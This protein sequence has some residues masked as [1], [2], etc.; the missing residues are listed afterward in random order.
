M[1]TVTR[2]ATD[3]NT[4][5]SQTLQQIT[6]VQRIARSLKRS[7][8]IRKYSHGTIK[9]SAMAMINQYIRQGG[10]QFST[11]SNQRELHVAM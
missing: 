4:H 5:N 2:R 10:K 8:L 11:S 7:A 1:N 3:T 9:R 6:D